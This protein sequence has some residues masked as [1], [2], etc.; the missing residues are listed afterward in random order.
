RILSRAADFRLAPLRRF[1]SAD[2][3]LCLPPLARH[4]HAARR[5]APFLGARRAARSLRDAAGGQAADPG[6]E[7]FALGRRDEVAELE[8]PRDQAQRLEA[9]AGAADQNVAI[10]EN[11]AGHRLVHMD[12]FD[13]VHVHLE[14]VPADETVL[15]DDAAFGDRHFGGEAPPPRADQAQHAEHQP[16]RDCDQRRY[17]EAAFGIGADLPQTNRDDHAEH[18]EHDAAAIHDPV[19]LTVE[20]D[21]FAGLQ[22]LFRVRHRESP[23]QETV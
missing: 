6:T 11:A 20:F 7:G 4:G 12:A 15:V 21:G 1:S 22:N 9:R 5:P 10:V 23:L 3:A 13:L 14:R 17:A 19:N 8:R 16:D 2:A 18:D